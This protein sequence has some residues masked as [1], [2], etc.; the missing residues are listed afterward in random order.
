[1]LIYLLAYPSREARAKSWKE[2]IADPDWKA[3]LKASEAHGKLV[4]KVD[5]IFMTTTDFSPLVQPSLTGEPRLFELRTY[6]VAPGKLDD[7]LARFRN[8]TM[9]LFAKQHMTNFGYFVPTEKKDGAGD[10]LIYMLAHKDKE[11]AL[12]SWKAFRA[13]PEWVTAKAESEV[14]GPLTV[15]DGVISVYMTPTDYSPT[16]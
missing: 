8:Y 1:L 14:N 16:K 7:L 10:K 12:A 15:K 5:S 6:H 9:A 13:D 2:F 4:I 11:A 3:A